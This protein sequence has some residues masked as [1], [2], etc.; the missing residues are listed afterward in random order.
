MEIREAIRLAGSTALELFPWGKAVVNVANEF[1]PDHLKLG[2][3]Q[4]GDDLYRAL[5]DLPP[6]LQATLLAKQIDLAVVHSNNERDK[7][8]ARERADVSGKTTRPTIAL[9]LTGMVVMVAFT[10]AVVFAI[11]SV[12]SGEMQDLGAL[13]GILKMTAEIL[14]YYF[15]SV[16]E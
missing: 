2:T 12:Q 6:E 11:T 7:V 1:L 5:R 10:I 16:S 14:K 9:I 4:S 8:I 3:H 15:G 13:E